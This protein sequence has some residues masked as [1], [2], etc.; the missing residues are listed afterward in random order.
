M[1]ALPPKHVYSATIR[2]QTESDVIVTVTFEKHDHSTEEEKHTLK[3]GESARA[4]EKHYQ[5][6]SATFRGHILKVEASAEGKQSHALEYPMP[7]VH[8]PVKDVNI[9]VTA[10]G[11]N[12]HVAFA[13]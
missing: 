8:S 5:S 6:G 9:A 4:D 7:G 12:L 10:E 2:N 11:D 3:A 1:Q 13:H